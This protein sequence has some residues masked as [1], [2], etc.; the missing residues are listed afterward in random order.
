MEAVERLDSFLSDSYFELESLEHWEL[1]PIP[2]LS[3]CSVKTARPFKLSFSN[4][5]N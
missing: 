2:L 1:I 3:I 4:F 5:V